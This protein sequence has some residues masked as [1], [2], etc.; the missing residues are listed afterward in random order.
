MI[1]VLSNKEKISTLR[2]EWNKLANEHKTPLLSFEWFFSCMEAFYSEKNIRV[3]I[4]RS[5]NCVK[6]IAPLVIVKRKSIKWLELIGVSLLYEPCGLL[7]DNNDSLNKLLVGVIDLKL[8]VLLQRIDTFSPIIEE[9][10]TVATL[11]GLFTEKETANSS[12]ISVNSSWK[13]YFSSLSSQRKYDLRRKRRRAEKHGKVHVK[14]FAPNLAELIRHLDNA[15]LVEAAG[16]KGRKGS[17]M[18]KNRKLEK[19][20][21]LFLES[22]CK[23][24]ILCLCFY[25]IAEKPVG[26]LIGLNDAD[27]FWVLK[28]G[29]DEHWANCS[30][31]IQ[32]TNETI[33]YAFESNLKSYEF[34]GSQEQWQ[35]VWPIKT[36]SF[37]AL[38][39]FPYSARGIQAFI[40]E[41]FRVF[42]KKFQELLA[43]NP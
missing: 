6:A 23:K 30:P 35:S 31:G 13:S 36:H 18:I 8:P 10:R 4:L 32:I 12:Y 37:S 27:C 15:F 41:S 2:F 40:L 25:Y 9:F 42:H 38:V 11:K 21:R 26:M 7:Y 33:R 22:A 20:F 17:A 28:L 16:W 34:L 3:V 19:F 5:D 24:N 29:Y 39:F 1:E 14:I 43:M